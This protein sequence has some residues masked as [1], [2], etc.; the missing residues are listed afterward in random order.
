LEGGEEFQREGE[1]M[2]E[3]AGMQVRTLTYAQTAYTRIQARTHTQIHTHTHTR[4]HARTC[5]HARIHVNTL[6]DEHIHSRTYTYIPKDAHTHTYT[7][8]HTHAQVRTGM[9]GRERTSAGSM[10]FLNERRGLSRKEWERM[11]E[12]EAEKRKKD[13]AA[14][15][16]FGSRGEKAGSDQQK[17]ESG[18]NGSE[19]KNRLTGPPK[20]SEAARSGWV[21][22]R[23]FVA[24]LLD[25][26]CMR[27]AQTMTAYRLA[28][29][30]GSLLCVS[31]YVCVCV[32]AIVCVCV[33]ASV[34]VRVC[35]IACCKASQSPPFT[36]NWK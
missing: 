7:H 30:Q 20:R 14:A 18:A 21:V 36:A 26:A 12:E 31:A 15:S 33:S 28:T 22:L 9:Q 1:G 11:K 23:N 6:K 27:A 8:T 4:A 25:Q 5:T 24:L 13:G 34:C 16:T 3:G 2:K 19:G 17:R 29:T 35:M 32:S 10:D